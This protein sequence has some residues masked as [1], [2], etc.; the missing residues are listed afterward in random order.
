[1]FVLGDGGEGRPVN[2]IEGAGVAFSLHPEGRH[3]EAAEIDLLRV[4]K[5]TSYLVL[6]PSKATKA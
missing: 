3:F 2:L 6:M 5:H 1:M 4:G